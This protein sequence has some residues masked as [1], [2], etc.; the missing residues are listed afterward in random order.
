MAD[1][2]SPFL[3]SNTRF[4][5]ASALE[6]FESDKTF[7]DSH[8]VVACTLRLSR[9]RIKTFNLVD[10]GASGYSFIDENFA[11]THQIPL[12]PLKYPRSLEG[13]DGQAALSG[14]ITKVAEIIMDLEGH[15]ERLFLFVTGLKHYPI[16]LGRPWLRRHNAV[17]DFGNNTLTFASPFCLTHC[18][19]H[20]VKV[21]AI[22]EEFLTPVESQKVWEAED[23]NSVKKVFEDITS[24]QIIS[25]SKT[26]LKQEE[27]NTS[28]TKQIEPKIETPLEPLSND[29]PSRIEKTIQQGLTPKIRYRSPCSLRTSTQRRAEQKTRKN[30]PSLQ[31]NVCEIEAA[32]FNRLSRKKN[33]DIFVLSMKEIDRFLGMEASPSPVPSLALNQSPSLVINSSPSPSYQPLSPQSSLSEKEIHLALFKMNKALTLHAT[34]TQEELDEYRERKNVDPAP[35]LPKQYH[36]FLDVFSKKNSDILPDHRPYDHAIKLK[37]ATQAPSQA[38]Y[39]M[40]RN[41]IEELRRY[42]DENLAKGFIRAS[43]SHAASPVM[44]VKKLEEDFAFV[45]TIEA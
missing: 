42:L 8:M 37:E 12:H 32:S 14:N 16:V 1:S 18:C 5:V 19:P 17:A 44:F 39:G 41:E 9:F 3:R 11:Q 31:L 10:C 30:I 40:S 21:H 43:R 2:F 25:T 38:L 35:F 36:D 34:V 20:P 23:I 13:F 33:Y 26:F 29:E 28:S 6:L 7:K 15:V 4:S 27:K 24:M 45:L 22:E